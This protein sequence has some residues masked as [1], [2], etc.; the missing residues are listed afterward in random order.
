M[1]SGCCCC[2]FSLH[3][4]TEVWGGLASFVSLICV[5][6]AKRNESAVHFLFHLKLRVCS[7]RSQPDA[8]Q[9]TRK[10]WWKLYIASCNKSN[11]L[12]PASRE[13]AGWLLQFF[14]PINLQILCSTVIEAI[15]YFVP[16]K[17]CTCRRSPR[18]TSY[19]VKGCFPKP[20]R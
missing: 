2:W 6:Q 20:P 18:Q 8:D 9:S 19:K 5:P 17:C 1:S 4:R 10:P 3:E 15:L 12:I 14:Q 13:L 7:V 11:T 16:H